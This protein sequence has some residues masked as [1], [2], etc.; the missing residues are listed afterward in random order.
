MEQAGNAHEDEQES[1]QQQ[2]HRDGSDEEPEARR[3]NGGQ[4]AREE[5][6]A[7]DDVLDAG[8]VADRERGRGGRPARTDA[9]RHHAGDRVP[10]LGDDA[11]EH[12][13]VAVRQPGPQRHD[14]R[15]AAGH[16]R[17]AGKDRAAAV[18]DRLHPGPGTDGLVED[19]PDGRRRG[20]EDGPVLGHCSQEGGVSP[21]RCREDEGTEDGD[22]KGSQR[23][24]SLPQS[25][26][27]RH[28]STR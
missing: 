17:L 1:A 7:G 26:W 10:V 5:Q 25:V 20:R 14:E 23:R 12:G 15:P 27:L 22:R 19:E 11:P 2:P 6:P 8:P 16:P 24:D 3:T 21:A 28:R 9:E 18:S 4:Q 13:V